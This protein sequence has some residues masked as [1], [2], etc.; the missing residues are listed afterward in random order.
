MYGT[1]F[2]LRISA[3]ACTV[4]CLSSQASEPYQEYRKHIESAQTIT[5]LTDDLMGDSVSLYNGATE[6]NA[7][8]IDL[9]GNNELPVQLR[10]RFSIELLPPSSH[11]NDSGDP[12]LR[13][14]GDWDVDVPYISAVYGPADWESTRCSSGYQPIVPAPLDVTDVWQG[15]SVH[16]PGS[17]D[18]KM[19]KLAWAEIPRPSDGMARKWTTRERDMF[20]CIPM[21]AGLAGEGFLMQTSTGLKYYFDIATTRNAGGMTYQPGPL[22]PSHSVRRVKYYLLASKIMDRSGNT[23]TF[24]YN[25]NGHPT[26]IVSSD[27]R[28]ISLSYSGTR[29]STATVHDTV[30]GEDR[31]WSYGYGTGAENGML[32][33]VTLPDGSAWGY[34]HTGT[35]AP[36]SQGIWDGG[37]GPHCGVKPPPL[38]ASFGL[39]VTHPS[40]AVG[41][42][43]FTNHR[44]PRSGV[45]MSACLDRVISSTHTYKL[46]IPNYFDVMTLTQKTITGPGL[47]SLAWSYHYPRGSILLWG[48][49]DQS[50]TYPC[51]TCVST[52]TVTADQPDG[53][54]KVYTY[55]FLYAA[56]EGRLLETKTLDADGVVRRTETTEYL[57]DALADNQNFYPLYGQGFGVADLS[58]LAVRPVIKHVI[59]Q[60]GATFTSQVET[61]CAPTGTYCFDEYGH[62]TSVVKSS[63]L[64]F[65]KNEITEY[66]DDTTLWIL[67]QASKSIIDGKAA[68]ETGFDSLARPVWTKAF[69]KLKQTLTYYS[70][71]TA[72]QK[73]TVASVS[74]GRDSSDFDTTIVLS[75]WK[76]GTPQNITYPA[77]DDQPGGA[78]RSATVDDNGWLR[79]V[80]DEN[81]YTTAYDYDNAG[82]LAEVVYPTESQ[83]WNSTLL[84]FEKSAAGKYG[85]PIG[86][87][88]QTV[89]TGNGYK[90]VYY[91]GL[92]RPVVE[93]SYDSAKAS[94]T[95]S[96]IAKRY[97]K[98]GRLAFQ[99]YP[100]R[101]L[102]SFGDTTLKGVRTSHD[103]LN[104][105]TQIQKDSEIGPLAT[106]IEYLSGFKTRVKSARQQGTNISTTTS[107]MAW[108]SPIADY[109]VEIIAPEG[110]YTDILRDSF[111]KPLSITRSNASGTTTATRSYVYNTA[112][113]LCKTIE[114]E[115]AST[116]MS[117]DGAGNLAWSAGGQS[118]PST[119]SC[120][121]APVAHRTTRT[122]DA[123]NRLTSLV[124]PDNRGN[125]VYSY[126]ADGRPGTVST[127]MAGED[128][129]ITSYAYNARRILTEE[130]LQVGSF[131]WPLDYTYDANGHLSSHIYPGEMTVSYAPNALGQPTRAGSYATGVIYHP[132]GGMAEFTYGNGVSHTMQQNDRQL[133]D[134]SVDSGGVLDDSYHYDGNGNVAA[135]S[136]GL[137]EH[138]GD[139]NMSYDQVDRLKTTTSPMF[140]GGT[141]YT[142]DA[143]D[144]LV[145]FKAPGRDHTYMYDQNW[146]LTNV[147]DTSGGETVIGLDY[148]AQGNLSNK[149]GQLFDFDYGNRLREVVGKERYLYDGHGRR[150]QAI[151]P[152]LGSI[153]S[154]YG[155]D[156]VLR[157]QR[158]ERKGSEVA[159]ITLN[160]SL[161]ARV[162]DVVAPPVPILTAPGYDTDGSYFVS[163]SSVTSATRYELQ[164]RANGGTWTQ[165]QS[166][167]ATSKA[168]VEKETGI[169]D[170]HV[171]ACNA[172]CGGWSATATVAVELPPDAAPTL[173]VPSTALNGNY[174]VTWSAPGGAETYMLQEKVGGG[175]WSTVYSGSEQSKAYSGKAG[176]TYAYQVRACNP[177]GCTNYSD[178]GTVNVVVPPTTKPTLT[179]PASN[180]TGSYTLHWTAVATASN[181][182]LEEQA[183]GGSWVEFGANTGTTQA[184]SG[185]A[186]G[187]YRYRVKGCNAAGCGPTSDIDTTVVLTAPTSAPVLTVPETN[188][189]GSY[190]VSWTTVSTATSY[191]IQESANGATWTALYTGSATSKTLNDKESGSYRYQGRACNDSG[192]GAYSAIKAIAVTTAPAT[193]AITKS[194]KFQRTVNGNIKIRCNVAWTPVATATTYDLQAYGGDLQYSGPETEVES[195]Y[196]SAAYCAPSHIV[197]ACNST[198]CSAWSTPPYPQTTKVVPGPG[199]E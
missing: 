3:V 69:G 75:D 21:Q 173:T 160:G 126:T 128:T 129:V 135:I 46:L 134:R 195:E 50:F 154:M 86:H 183:G 118:A 180:T 174:S 103:A 112:Q 119:S 127:S 5:A 60:D 102:A 117:Y 143:L 41:A 137:P 114:P 165:I 92:W 179:A 141:L 181:Y 91:D 84:S 6:F 194:I 67:G 163:W 61:G 47:A 77:T 49:R 158:D 123:R 98:S 8:D 62:P 131:A 78:I 26:S 157:F 144:N 22:L 130:S 24:T 66:H 4:A 188:T 35:L 110:I 178:T 80:T 88:R 39:T 93:E 16:V 166:S 81:H 38:M 97:D 124:F 28:S 2:W 192:C 12:A 152:T 53:T 198:D 1:K 168:L 139:R 85:L 89:H 17:G 193:P 187:T 15:N 177:A 95:R 113:E 52:K 7:V 43:Q 170:Y 45:H 99:S 65:S 146:R 190:T 185:R 171:R 138:R 186:S 30:T 70:G 120:G 83:T 162:R 71:S 11:G 159:Y 153:Y 96:V 40:G 64:G 57:P 104:R 27:G 132:N 20:S 164:E 107:F 156:G 33:S 87:W 13:G 109:P 116:L 142:Y 72:S 90:V 9:P 140:A 108:D 149:S 25:G 94:S 196:S 184:V 100:V 133:P 176:G 44:H 31:T 155:Q 79:S 145:R 167:A 122:Y 199:G 73:G 37:G 48:S 197:R 182:T 172:Q 189:T 54:T 58:T 161:V 105:V 59:Q 121:T 191:E 42:F 115:T 51:T 10:R 23:V 76:R 36:L 111:G 136:D 175:V 125:T 150:V 56:N 55:G 148:D 18:R 32:T 82:R 151:H 34:A 101:S 14:I 63:S 74:D 147:T 68:F 106:T 29:L 169:Y 19:L